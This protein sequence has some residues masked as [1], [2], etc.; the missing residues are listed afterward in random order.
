MSDLLNC[1]LSKKT[2][3]IQPAPQAPHVIPIPLWDT[4]YFRALR[5]LQKNSVGL[6]T[7]HTPFVITSVLSTPIHSVTTDSSCTSLDPY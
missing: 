5:G 4:K 7:V 3:G 2:E 1:F 6:Q